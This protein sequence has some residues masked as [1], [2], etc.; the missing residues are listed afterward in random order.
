MPG[1]PLKSRVW[2]PLLLGRPLKSP[3]GLSTLA[4]ALLPHTS[5]KIG[6]LQ[7][8]FHILQQARL[9]GFSRIPLI[10]VPTENP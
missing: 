3:F 5:F 7:H 9:S 6:G 1:S 2:N 10:R 4:A 8:L